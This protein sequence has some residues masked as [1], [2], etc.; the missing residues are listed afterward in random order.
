MTKYRI[1]DTDTTLLHKGRYSA[2]HTS[3]NGRKDGVQILWVA[4]LFDETTIAVENADVI[5]VDGTD[6]W[7]GKAPYC[8]TETKVVWQGKEVS[9]NGHRD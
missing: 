2:V 7:I 8:T 5:A 3:F 4:H 1:I 9:T 6:L